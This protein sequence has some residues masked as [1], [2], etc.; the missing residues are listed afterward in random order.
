MEQLDSL[1]G[2]QQLL[3]PGLVLELPVAVTSI[4]L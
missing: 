2:E 4:R 1:P 3:G